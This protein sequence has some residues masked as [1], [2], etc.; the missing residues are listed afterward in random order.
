MKAWKIFVAFG[1]ILIAV[2][3]IL[4][5]VDVLAPVTAVI[6]NISV[7]TIALGLLLIAFAVERVIKG[8]LHEIFIPL[9]LLFMLFEKNIAKLLGLSSPNIVH[10]G[11]LFISAVLLSIGFGLLIGNIK[12]KLIKKKVYSHSS[13]RVEYSDEKVECS[14]GSA[15]VYIDSATLSP[16]F[17][18]NSFGS[19]AV[20]FENPERYMG[21]GVV[22]V[23]NNFGQ[24][25]LHVPS[26]WQVSVKNDN[27]LAGSSIPK[28]ENVNGPT[29]TIYSENNFGSLNVKYI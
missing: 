23:E 19:C 20:Y 8:K 17:V 6:G 22:K 28:H 2:I 4:D 5:A 27:N 11:I 25:T 21:G 18:E 7:I 14:F 29:L 10:N 12:K 15:T 1:L 24:M 13:P 9:A 26:S 16:R 3:L